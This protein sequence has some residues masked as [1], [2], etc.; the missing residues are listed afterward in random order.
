LGGMELTGIVDAVL[1]DHTIADFKTGRFDPARHERY[2][3]QLRLYALALARC[4]GV[5]APEGWLVYVDEG[6]TERIP[7]DGESV[8]AT[9]TAVAAALE[10]AEP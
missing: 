4:R 3:W 6:R 1:E 2:C 7:L 8:R 9:E 5:D 10:R